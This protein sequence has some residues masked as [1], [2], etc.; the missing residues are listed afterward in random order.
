[1]LPV[2]ETKRP[3]TSLPSL[4]L[5]S[6]P[7]LSPQVYVRL[8]GFM[9]I[10]G[11]NLAILFGYKFYTYD[12]TP[13]WLAR[14]KQEYVAVVILIA[15]NQESFIMITIQENKSQTTEYKKYYYY[16]RNSN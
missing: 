4:S 9:M 8:M 13:I 16:D 5:P 14:F 10:V 7:S 1:M 6:H 2:C 15:T 11:I 3:S 12:N